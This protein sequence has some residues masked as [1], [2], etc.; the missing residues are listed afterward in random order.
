MVSSALPRRIV[1][2]SASVGAGHDGAAA[3][4]AHRFTAAGCRVTRHDFLDLLP[5]TIG[6]LLNGAYKATLK[7]IPGAWEFLLTRMHGSHGFGR[8]ALGVAKLGRRRIL[9]AAAGA[10]LIVSTYPLASKALGHLRAT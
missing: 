9:R 7:A 2:I 10:D 4:L 8:P 3:E 6:P 1:V 5:P